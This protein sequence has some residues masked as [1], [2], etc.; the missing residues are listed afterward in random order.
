EVQE[1]R[2]IQVIALQPHKVRANGL[3]TAVRMDA[4]FL[5]NEISHRTGETYCFHARLDV[6]ALESSSIDSAIIDE[7]EGSAIGTD[8]HHIGDT[9]LMPAVFGDFHPLT[10]SGAAIESVGGPLL[11]ASGPDVQVAVAIP[12]VEAVQAQDP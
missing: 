4:A 11:L 9:R 8:R 1:K 2:F 7:E 10:G 3:D 5:G 6:D 12:C